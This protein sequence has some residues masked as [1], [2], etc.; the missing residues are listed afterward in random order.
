[1]QKVHIRNI[2]RLFV[3]L[4]LPQGYEIVPVQKPFGFT[5]INKKTRH[6]YDYRLELIR[7]ADEDKDAQT[8]LNWGSWAKRNPIY[9]RTNA[10]DNC[11]EGVT[12]RVK[13]N[14][15]LF[16]FRKVEDL[17]ILFSIG[18]YIDGGLMQQGATSVVN[19]LPKKRQGPIDE[20]SKS[21]SKDSQCDPIRDPQKS[22]Y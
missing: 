9:F 21:I 19:L 12:I 8:L 10:D 3:P 5:V 11:V 7:L 13:I 20:E 22:K 17:L 16:D 14:Y 1:M 2:F 18:C 6:Q 15:G 4:Q